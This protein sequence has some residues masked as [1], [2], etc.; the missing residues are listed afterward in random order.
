MRIKDNVKSVYTQIIVLCEIFHISFLFIFKHFSMQ[1]PLMY[2]IGSVIFYILMLFVVLKGYYR[3][4][5]VLVH[6]EVSAFVTVTVL[7]G[8]YSSDFALYLISMA[9]FVYFNPFKHRSVTYIFSICEVLLYIGLTLHCSH[10]YSEA[11]VHIVFVTIYNTVL[12]VGIILIG[13]YISDVSATVTHR[14]LVDENKTLNNLANYDRLTGLQSRRMFMER[15]K[16]SE[17]NKSVVICIGD[18]DDFKKIND[19][20][21]H[22]CGD[23]VLQN[24]SE[25]MRKS[26][27]LENVDIC[28]WGGEEFVFMFC[29]DDIDSAF[30]KVENLRKTIENKNFV[31]ENNNIY[32][33]MTFGI[34]ERDSGKV[35]DV[36]LESADKLLYR[37]KINGK[38]VVVKA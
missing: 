36:L 21:G 13:A 19:T 5:I 10:I 26:L 8:G 15:I 27:G 1:I 14:K 17:D 11:E 37:G 12:A 16:D 3:V 20:Y 34:I 7:N 28:R 38:N 35:D 9:T 2:D 25:I 30:V 31:Y 6:L 23:Y 4:C 22:L 24:I 29:N 33:T 32:V 18:I